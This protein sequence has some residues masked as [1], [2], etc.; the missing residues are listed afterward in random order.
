MDTSR[1]FLDGIKVG[2]SATDYR[3]IHNLQIT[4]FEGTN[5]IPVGNL[6]DLDG[7]AS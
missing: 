1:A 5:W 3:A 7:I 2:N 6:V 4:R